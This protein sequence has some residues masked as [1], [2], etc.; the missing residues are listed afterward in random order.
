MT[1]TDVAQ[2]RPTTKTEEVMFT[3]EKRCWAMKKGHDEWMRPLS[4]TDEETKK[5]DEEV[6]TRAFR[7][8]S[9]P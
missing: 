2:D 6:R 5:W 1:K 8:R 3:K 7:G 4:I 9:W